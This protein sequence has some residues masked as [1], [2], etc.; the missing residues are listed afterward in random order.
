MSWLSK[1]QSAVFG[2]TTEAEYKAYH[3]A[4]SEALWLLLLLQ[5][6]KVEVE[7]SLVVYSDNQRAMA[8]ARNPIYH[9]KV[10]HIDVSYHF[11]R[12]QVNEGVIKLVYCASKDNLADMFTKALN[13]KQLKEILRRCGVGPSPWT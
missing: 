8:L 5:K 11:T 4:T 10:K 2:S 6:F 3:F 9:S 12:E 7:V 1:K 13:G